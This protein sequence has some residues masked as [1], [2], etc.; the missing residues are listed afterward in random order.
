MREGSNYGTHTR[1]MFE[2]VGETSTGGGGES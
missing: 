1:T 2:E